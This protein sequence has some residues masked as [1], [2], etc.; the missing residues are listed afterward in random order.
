MYDFVFVVSEMDPGVFEE[1]L[2][3]VPVSGIPKRGAVGINDPSG[4]SNP[5]ISE[6]ARSIL[7]TCSIVA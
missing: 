4:S 3:A 2:P 7:G 5:Y 1:V 6:N